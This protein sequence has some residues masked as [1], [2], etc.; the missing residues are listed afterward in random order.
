[1]SKKII[2]ASASPRRKKL[3]SQIGL[4]FTIEP[5]NIKEESKYFS[6]F[7]LIA[8][9]LAYQKAK[10]VAKNHKNSIV[11]G[12]DTIVVIDSKIL[13][14][15]V[16]EYEAKLMLN[17]LSGTWHSVFTGLALIDTD[18]NVIVRDFEESN[19]KFR[20][21]SDDQIKNYIKTGESMDK[22]GAYG[23]QGKGALLV[24]KINGCYYNIVG[25]PLA[26]LSEMFLKLGVK[27]L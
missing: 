21:L 3:L 8:A 14:K 18:S 1:M 10:D 5:S 9:D 24:E 25:L 22:A 11:I 23:I 6:D 15:P 17:E 13:G 20:N 12:A 16:T 7:G 4:N 26:K 27:I 2:L 19:V